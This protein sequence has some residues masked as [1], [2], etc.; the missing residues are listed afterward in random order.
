LSFA[1][2]QLEH[3]GY[4]VLMALGEQRGLILIRASLFRNAAHAVSLES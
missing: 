2:G 3:C 1:P 4:A